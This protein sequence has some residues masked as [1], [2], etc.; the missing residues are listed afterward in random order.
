MV[1]VLEPYE[2]WE[3][4]T[5][6]HPPKFC[7]RCRAELK[8]IQ[9]YWADSSR[10]SSPENPFRGIGYDCYCSSCGWSGSIEPD[11]D[12]SIVDEHYRRKAEEKEE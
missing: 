5:E 12:L 9:T 4:E 2:K 10:F 1:Y 8:D 6:K 3:S 11:E 7:P